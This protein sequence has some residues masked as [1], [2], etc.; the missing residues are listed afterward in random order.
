MIEIGRMHTLEVDRI[1]R[2]G[3]WLR[4]GQKLVML[5]REE[6]SPAVQP[7]SRLPVFI[8]GEADGVLLATLKRPRALLGEFAL[9]TVT[10]IARPGAF[11]DWGLDKDLLVPF[12]KQPEP[13]QVGTPY[14]VRVCLDK[15]GRLFGNAKIDS[16]LEM[17]ATDELK[18]GQEVSVIL[19]QFTELGAKVIVNH[20]FAGLLYRDEVSGK[21]RAG[22]SFTGYVKHIREDRRIDV[23]LRPL[24]AEAV[25]VGKNKV[26]EALQKDGFLPLHDGSTPKEI[27]ERLGMSKKSFKKVV[28]GLYKEG[29]VELT[30][31]GIRLKG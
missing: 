9:L 5:A 2:A 17:E 8:Y 21:A 31:E 12:Q 26:L 16:L 3:V 27:E 1:D 18:V 30:P 14:M 4:G 10:N 7:G 6:A 20:R 22:D 13:M 11:L 15:Q 25:A 29:K 19:W 24:G 28:G 23:T